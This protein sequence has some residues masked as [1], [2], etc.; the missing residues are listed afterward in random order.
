MN[1]GD[2]LALIRKS[3]GFT[4]ETLAKAVG[5]AKTTITGY[6]RGNR[7]PNIPMIFKLS[8]V[9]EVTGNALLGV[10]DPAQQVETKNYPKTKNV[11]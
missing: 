5:V 11:Y 10:P 1:F 6:E 8:E 3:K 4:Q 2:N 7:E 9:L